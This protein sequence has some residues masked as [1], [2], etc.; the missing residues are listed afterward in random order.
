V[1]PTGVP[2]GSSLWLDPQKTMLRQCGAEDGV[3]ILVRPDGYI[4]TIGEFDSQA[5]ENG[6]DRY[7]TRPPRDVF[8]DR[9]GS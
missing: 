3:M 8:R 5:S 1:S 7:L 9:G 4:A 2:D 6:L